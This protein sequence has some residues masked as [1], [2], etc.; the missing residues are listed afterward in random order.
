MLN[1]QKKNLGP[2]KHRLKFFE[3]QQQQVFAAS[4]LIQIHLNF[5]QAVFA[6][7]LLAA[8]DTEM[9]RQGVKP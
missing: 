4:A 6:Q 1:K 3:L 8:T 2:G 5:I 7:C 9:Q